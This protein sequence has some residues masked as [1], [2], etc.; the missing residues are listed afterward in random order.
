MFLLPC[1]N[2]ENGIS[3]AVA[4]IHFMV[5]CF[6]SGT[7]KP[8]LCAVILKLNKDIEDNPMVWRMRI[9]LRKNAETET[10][11]ELADNNYKTIN[12]AL[13][14]VHS[15][16]TDIKKYLALLVQVQMPV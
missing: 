15:V 14:V 13:V 6:T 11:T 7:G 9:G 8:L 2:K 3:G 1:E 10:T 5:L 16:I 4:D 12:G